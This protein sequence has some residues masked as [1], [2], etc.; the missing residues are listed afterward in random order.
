M[1][2]NLGKVNK[3]HDEFQGGLRVVRAESSCNL[4]HLNALFSKQTRMYKIT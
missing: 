1:K 3:R 4:I 2:G